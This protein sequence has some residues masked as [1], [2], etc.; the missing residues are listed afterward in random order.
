MS[1]GRKSVYSLTEKG[2]A[3][4]VEI[5]PIHGLSV[6]LL[7]ISYCP[8]SFPLYRSLF[9]FHLLTRT[10][11]ERKGESGEE[12][13]DGGEGSPDSLLSALPTT[14]HIPPIG[15]LMTVY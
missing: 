7:F 1:S 6:L 10:L 15:T 13:N 5:L 3:G 11:G 9:L 8:P 14:V 2:M 12:E 4:C